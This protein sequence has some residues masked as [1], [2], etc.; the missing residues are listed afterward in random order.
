MK[1]TALMIGGIATGVLL[2]G[3]WAVAQSDPPS[4]DGFA[5]PCMQG[6]RSGGMGP[7]M[8]RGMGPGMM[9]GMGAGMMHGGNVV[10]LAD[11]AQIETL[12]SE[13]G[14]TA[15]QEPAWTAYAKAIQDTATATKSAADQLLAA[16]DDTQK[17]KARTILPG[18]ASVGPGRRSAM[19]GPDLRH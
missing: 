11:P 15:A 5:P 13:L 7:G 16:L 18:L 8:M 6:G 12:R 17:A 3:G 10:T 14:I 9:Q 1:K 2:T 19:P 4:S